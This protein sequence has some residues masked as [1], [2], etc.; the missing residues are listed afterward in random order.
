LLLG[1][2]VS[3]LLH[4]ILGRVVI[5]RLTHWAQTDSP[6]HAPH[7]PQA[8]HASDHH[9]SANAIFAHHPHLATG[10]RKGWRYHAA[11]AVIDPTT[12]ASQTYQQLLKGP[13]AALWS[14]GASN[15]IG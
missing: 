5:L 1:I 11:N 9:H 3:L 13:D 14:K 15:E 6:A 2:L 12:G 8:T 7:H 10:G 4:S